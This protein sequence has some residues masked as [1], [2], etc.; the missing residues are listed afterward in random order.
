MLLLVNEYNFRT[1]SY[2]VK[3]HANGYSNFDA[4]ITSKRMFAFVFA[5]PSECYNAT[6][7]IS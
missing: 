5:F 3:A 7:A 2:L 6:S 1:C 4:L